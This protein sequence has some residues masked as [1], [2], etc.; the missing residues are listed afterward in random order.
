M[1]NNKILKISTA[2]SRKSTN[3]VSEQLSWLDFVKR[4]STPIVT[5]ETFEQFMRLKKSQQDEL[6]DIGRICSRTTKEQ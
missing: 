4:I 5:A 2:K 1:Q 3:W 6:K